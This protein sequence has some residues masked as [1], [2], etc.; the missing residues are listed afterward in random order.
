MSADDEVI[1]AS[2]HPEHPLTLTQGERH[3]LHRRRLGMSQKA[4]ARALGVSLTAYSLLERDSER[5]P[6]ELAA[7]D[8]GPLRDHERCLIYRKRS[9]TTQDEIA[10]TLEVCRYTVQRMER[11][12][13]SC[14]DLLEYWEA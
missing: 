12:E 2:C 13:V 9:N 3:L 4:Q 1:L 5:A 6:K 10:A 14:A 8:L 11:G 7:P